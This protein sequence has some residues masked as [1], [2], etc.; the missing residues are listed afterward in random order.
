MKLRTKL[1]HILA[2][3]TMTLL[4]W[5]VLLL[6]FW[7]VRPYQVMDIKNSNAIQVEK[8]VY[9][10][11]E[12]ITYYIDYCKHISAKAKVY[13]SLVNGTVTVFTPVEWTLSIWCKIQK[14][15]DLIIPEYTEPDTYHLEATLEYQV[16]LIRTETVHRRSVDFKVVE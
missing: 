14:K 6:L 10:A 9:K 12:R 1:L 11:W 13:R 7:R 5:V 2:Y 8:T 4:S 15:S 3:V 16:N